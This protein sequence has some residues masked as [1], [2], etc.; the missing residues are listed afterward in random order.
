MLTHNIIQKQPIHVDF[1][2]SDP[3][4]DTDDM[5]GEEFSG[6]INSDLLAGV[7][8]EEFDQCWE[9]AVNDP[10][11]TDQELSDIAKHEL[12]HQ[13]LLHISHFKENLFF[14]KI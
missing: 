9:D 4:L 13:A 12:G 8:P 6:V 7:G 14:W 5:S 1:S 11:S 3:D 2:E 10:A